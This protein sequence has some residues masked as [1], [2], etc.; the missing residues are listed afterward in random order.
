MC[1]FLAIFG[2]P[3]RAALDAVDR[4]IDVMADRGP[5]GRGRW[6]SG[7]FLLG[8]RRLAITDAAG[9]RQPMVSPDGRFAVS[10]NGQL[11]NDAE[12][13]QTLR[14]DGGWQFRTRCDTETVLAAFAVWGLDC[15]T[16]FRGSFGLAAVDTA[17]GVGLLAR[18][19]C[20]VKP[21][22]YSS[23]GGSLVAA[24]AA[25]AILEHPDCPKRPNLRAVSH[26]LTSFRTTL[27][28]ET[29]FEGIHQLL[30]GERL[31][32]KGEQA[33]VNRWWSLPQQTER[34]P[35]AEVMRL[36]D[37]GLDEAVR[38]RL[39]G[40]RKIGVFLSGGVDSAAVA[41]AAV[42]GGLTLDARSAGDEGQAA[43]ITAKR[44]GGETR[45]LTPT[46]DAYRVCWRELSDATR[47]PCSTPSDPVI[48]AMA[49]SM[50]E[51][52]DVALS[53]EGADELLYGYS[54]QHGAAIDRDRELARRLRFDAAH[55][56]QELLKRG[57]DR[58]LRRRVHVSAEDLSTG[59]LE[60]HSLVSPAAKPELLSAE[61]WSAADR[62]RPIL[63]RYT[64]A[65]RGT[66]AESVA[67]RTF[68]LLHAINLEGQLARL[69]T[70]TMR[71]SLEVRAPFTDP[72][73]TRTAASLPAA[74][75]IRRR[76]EHEADP[77]LAYET[78][79]P[80]RAA[81]RRSLG[82][83]I[84]DRAKVSFATPAFGW[85]ANEWA[86]ESRATLLRSPFLRS[87]LRTSALARIA[88]QPSLHA[89]LLWPLMNL[90]EWGDRE[91]H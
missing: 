53:G 49:R 16:R 15:L 43:C 3:R 82:P 34:R 7:R 81:V 26:Y 60:S 2:Q 30:P 44:V 48:L 19:P 28:R 31:I 18:D 42:R 55:P 24:S 25:A 88:S 76:S 67:R 61:A 51:T 46:A 84:A 36:I 65:L 74:S 5:D 37:D 85:L 69:D 4:M 9:G 8:H 29:L 1:G 22:F 64:A 70:A 87:I 90:A 91:F 72:H 83:E 38:V 77:I 20:G 78:K 62:D 17:E 47:L 41:A 73:L 57:A 14:R 27:G 10:Y 12:L 21:V 66:P 54:A 80:L 33:R 71:A 39:A 13:R 32:W 75:M 52:A 68:R 50:K 79:R 11:Y 59:F 6:Q 89:T 40:D 58:L 63:A 23:C 35:D 56:N 86:A 45:V